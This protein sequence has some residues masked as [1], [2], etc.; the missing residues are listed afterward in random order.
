M[1]TETQGKA[2]K[3]N[4][5]GNK[6]AEENPKAPKFTSPRKKDGDK[7]VDEGI[8][9]PAGKYKAACWV[10]DDKNGNKMLSISLTEIEGSSLAGASS[11]IF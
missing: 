7:W 9:I 4:L 3:I 5:F 11:E 1:A 10:R 6:R 8:E 2:V